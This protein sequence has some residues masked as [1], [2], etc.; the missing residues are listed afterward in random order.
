MHVRPFPAP[1]P[2]LSRA[3]LVL[4]AA[5]CCACVIPPPGTWSRL[6]TGFA[7]WASIVLAALPYIVIGAIAAGLTRRLFRRQTVRSQIAAAL[8]A[9]FNPGCDCA[10]NGFAGALARARPA[11][12]GFALTFAAASSPVSLLVTYAA[13]G[14]R[15]T[16]A[17]AVGALIAAALTAIAWSVV[18]QAPFAHGR[19]MVALLHNNDIVGPTFMVGHINREADPDEFDDLA[20]ALRGIACAACATITAKA[21]IPSSI[22]AHLHPAGAALFGA[23]LSPCSTA[24]PLLAAALLREPRAQLAFMLAA[25]CLDIRQML[26]LHRHFGVVRMAA[27]AVCAA[28]ACALA[29]TFA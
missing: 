29:I 14:A 4:A 6:S 22:L 27:A 21:L 20:A 1:S 3:R 13:F 12:A 19:P 18:G 2:S 11:L 17:R 25:Q 26:L 5:V 24:D 28:T 15:M 9:V 8:F 16:L 7:D 10:L 23:L